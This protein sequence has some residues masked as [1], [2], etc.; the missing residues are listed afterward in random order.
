MVS[1]TAVATRDG[2]I[3]AKVVAVGDDAK[4]DVATADVLLVQLLS[5]SVSLGTSLGLNAAA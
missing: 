2:T 5:S 1:L 4:L 3:E